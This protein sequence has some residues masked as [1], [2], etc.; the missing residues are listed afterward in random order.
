MEKKKAKKKVESHPPSHKASEDQAGK[1]QGTKAAVKVAKVVEE[2]IITPELVVEEEPKKITKAGK[3]SAK[4]I[5]EAEEEAARKA[6]VAEEPEKKV[7]KE[8]PKARPLIERRSKKYRQAFETI[9]KNVTFSLEEATKLAVNTSVTKF[10]ATVEL[11]VRLN[12][13]PK[14]AEQN[15]RDTLVL[16]NGSGK[17]KRVAVIGTPDE[18]ASAKQ[19][20]ADL[21]GEDDLIEAITEGK[22][23]F[24]ILIA[25]P[26]TMSKLGKLARILGPKG[27]MPNPKSGTVTANISGAVKDSKT[28]KIEYRTDEQGIIH[29]V[30]GKVSFG[31][32]KL[33]QN[34]NAVLSSIK[35]NKPATVKES[36]IVSIYL[37]T[38]MGP[39][40][41]VSL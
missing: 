6:K 29:T 22:I 16:P 36:Y 37:A 34:I 41:K 31:E 26:K 33:I 38:S 17:T 9:P 35:A 8:T 14:K 12:V 3:K 4:A 39:S 5:R 19:A 24:D 1:E 28:G 27:L 32:A 40:I 30:V 11:H 13:D 18:Q 21:V 25:S 23:S 15:I 20:G 7:K 2:P 10:D